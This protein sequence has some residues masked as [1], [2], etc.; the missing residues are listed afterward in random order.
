MEPSVRISDIGLYLRCPRLVYFDAL[1]NLPRKNDIHR[2]LLRSLMLSLC[3]KGDL[4]DQLR[5][6]LARLA[7]EVSLIYD[8][9]TAGLQQALAELEGKI[10]EISQNLLP[11]CDILFPNEVEVDLRSSRLGLTGRLDRIIPGPLPSLIR[12]GKAPKDGVWKRDR[13]MLAG[14]A[15]LL[16]EKNGTKINRGLIE[17]PLS[18]EVREVQIHE[19]DKARMLRI[20]DRIRQIKDGRLPDKPTDAPCDKCEM[21]DRCETKRQLASKFF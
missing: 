1:G 20:R 10:P 3:D 16:G 18:G 9:D 21:I 7:Q 8:V 14:Y 4:E 5:A 19:V 12:T 17:Y 13:M 11:Y 15:L 6:S 2:L